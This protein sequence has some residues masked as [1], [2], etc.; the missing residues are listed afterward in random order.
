MPSTYLTFKMYTQD[1]SKSLVRAASRVEVAREEKYY[2]ENIGKVTSVDD[3]LND[4]R[5]LAY[6]MKAHGLEDMTYAKAFMRKVLESDLTDTKSFARQLVDSRYAIF[7]NSFSFMKDGTVRSS[8]PYV[9]N[10]FQGDDT[11]GL[12]SEHRVNKGATAATEVQYYQS[13]LATLTS[14]DDLVADD[15]LFAFAL[16]AYGLDPKIASE[17]TIRNVLTSDLSDP[18]SVANRLGDARYVKLANAFSFQ[19]DGSAAAGSAQSDAQLNTTIFAYYD[20]SGSGAS[21][22]AAAQR[23][24]YYTSTV[25]SVASVDDLLN[26]D[27]LYTYALTAFGLNPNLQS[28]TTIRQVL[29]SDLSDPDSFANTLADTRYRTLAAAFNFAT[30]GT[31]SGS[32]GAQSADQIDSTTELYL[33]N[34]DDAA[35]SAEAVATTF[36]RNRINLMTS[37]DALMDNSTLYNYVLEAYGFDPKTTS[38]SNIR[39]A[40]VSDVSN[41]TSFANLQSDP[42]YRELAAAFNFAPDGSVLLPREAQTEDEEVATIQLY[43]TRIGTADS[44]E[45]QAIEENAYYHNTISRVRSLDDFLDDKRMVAYVLKAYGLESERISNDVL[46]KVLTS[47]PFDKDS[48]VSKLSDSRYRDLAAAFNFTSDGDIGRAAAQQVQTRSSLLKTIDLHIQQTMES[49]AGAQNEG[50]RLALYF[51]RKAANVTSVF[52]IL[53]DK[54][55]FEVVRTALGLPVGMSQADIDVQGA[56]ITKRLDLA[57]LKD[58][59]KVSKFLARFSALYDVANGTSSTA[60]AA[61]IILGGGSG[62]GTNVNLLASLQSVTLGRL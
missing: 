45:A 50:V 36:Y 23:T 5:L 15:R 13:K 31:V 37:V 42:R 25:G 60:S 28:K 56:M 30:D 54:A 21:P 52:G 53:A 43:N 55:L 32:D 3:L 14:V 34:Y 41:P 35:V 10:E 47:D 57:D 33:T 2:Q 51:Q 9:Q 62:I 38:K 27:T 8:L 16:T 19:T 7:A 48:Y 6:A 24:Q 17:T 18:D 46:R 29:T 61:S 40:L 59:E 39:Q 4:R 49:D 44:E 1:I 22:A 26:D 12:Y 11:V 20:A 58:P